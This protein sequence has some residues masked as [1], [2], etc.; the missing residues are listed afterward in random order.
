MKRFISLLAL[1]LLTGCGTLVPHRVEFFQS[2]VKAFPEQSDT[3]KED[4]RKAAALASVRASETYL[5]AVKANSPATITNPAKETVDL[6]HAVSTSLGP[7]KYLY[8]GK[9]ASKNLVESL[10]YDVAKFNGK[11]EDFKQRNDKFEGKKIEGTGLFSIGYFTYIGLIFLV[12]FLAWTALKIYGMANPL[13]GAGTSLVGRVSSSL[14]SRAVSEISAGGEAFKDYLENS[15]LSKEVQAQVLDLFS[16]AHVEAQSTDVQRIVST[17]TATP[18]A[19]ST[20]APTA[21]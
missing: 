1:C 14:L 4:Q 2:K 10:N 3:L 21:K 15:D 16:R 18:P 12:L 19:G 20:T 5:A 17:L 9:D 11:V 8:T 6:T 13:V 7:P